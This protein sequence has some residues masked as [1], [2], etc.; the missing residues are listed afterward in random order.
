MKL[1]EK[2]TQVHATEVLY[3]NSSKLYFDAAH[4]KE[5]K[6]AD[7]KKLAPTK[8]VVSDGTDYLAVTSM[9]IDGSTVTVGSTEYSI[10]E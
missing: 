5:V 3:V 9:A 6:Q 4:T 7:A 1:F 10:A 2:G 8:F